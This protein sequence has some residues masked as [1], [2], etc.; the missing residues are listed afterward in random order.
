MVPFRRPSI[1][2]NRPCW[3]S[4]FVA[5]VYQP[6][7]VAGSG[8]WLKI[9]CKIPVLIPSMKYLMSVL[10]LVSLARPA[11]ILNCAI[12]LPA[13]SFC[14]LS[15]RNCARASPSVSAAEKAFLSSVVK[16][17]KVL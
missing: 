15:C 7:I 11:R 2:W 4:N 9:F 13:V 6:S 5:E 10:L 3:E 14:C 17:V 8:F 16:A 12:Y 1:S